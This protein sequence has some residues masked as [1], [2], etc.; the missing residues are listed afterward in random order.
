LVLDELTVLG[1]RA[2]SREDA[3]QAL[4]A[5]ANGDVTPPIAFRR[6]LSEVNS[7]LEAL[8]DGNALGRIVLDV[9]APV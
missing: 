2:A 8:R 4:G 3:A 9:A 7:A 5:V 6:P 1:S